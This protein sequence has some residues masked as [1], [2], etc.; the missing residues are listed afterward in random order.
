MTATKPPSPRPLSI[1]LLSVLYITGAPVGLLTGI[2][3][4]QGIFFGVLTS[5]WPGVLINFCI[6]GLSL[7]LGLGLWRLRETARKITIWFQIYNLVNIWI[8]L[9]FVLAKLKTAPPSAGPTLASPTL[10][11]VFIIWLLRKHKPVFK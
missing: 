7:Y 2:L 4:N 11:T 3:T 1:K 8:Y 6:A 10:M 9:L 5:G